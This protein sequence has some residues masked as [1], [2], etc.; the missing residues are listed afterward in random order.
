MSELGTRESPIT[1]EEDGDRR[2]KY[3]RCS[4]CSRIE[5]CTP[6]FDFFKMNCC[7]VEGLLCEPCH[8]DHWRTVHQVKVFLEQAPP[9]KGNA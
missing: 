4:K 6:L 3:C 8:D 7:A 1:R 5:P 9:A 2:G